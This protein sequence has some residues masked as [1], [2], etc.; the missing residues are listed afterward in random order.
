MQTKILAAFHK[1]CDGNHLFSALVQPRRASPLTT[2]SPTPAQAGRMLTRRNSRTATRELRYRE[3][4]LGS[5]NPKI[6]HQQSGRCWRPG[7]NR[8]KAQE[9]KNCIPVEGMYIYIVK[10]QSIL[11]L[12]SGH[13]FAVRNEGPDIGKGEPH[14]VRH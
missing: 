7:D 2:S 6:S 1:S 5:L 8:K 13:L 10:F 14:E 9:R 4:S 12:E 3:R 11:D